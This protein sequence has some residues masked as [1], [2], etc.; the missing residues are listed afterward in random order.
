MGTSCPML[1]ATI[2]A[3]GSFISSLRLN[4][5]AL[6]YASKILMT[7]SM[8]AKATSKIEIIPCASKTRESSNLGTV[9]NVNNPQ[10]PIFK[11]L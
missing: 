3:F 7:Y 9:P 6:R 8:I 4:R 5:S 2:R 1:L 11:K 10:K